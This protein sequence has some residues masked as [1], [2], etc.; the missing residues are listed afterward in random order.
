MLAN[1]N[2]TLL[3][4]L[5]PAKRQ[6]DVRDTKLK[7]F[8]IR[9][10]PSGKMHYVCSFKR[11]RRI[12]LGSTDVLT[13]MQARDRAKEILGD[14]TK[15]IDPHKI[16]NE[17]SVLSLK[18]F[19]ENEY[20]AWVTAHRKSG[21]E[22]IARIKRCFFKSFGNKPLHE[23]VIHD[24]EKWRTQ[25][26]NQ[27]GKAISVNRDLIALR[28]AIAQAVNWGLIEKHPLE[29]LKPLKVDNSPKVRYLNNE[30]EQHLREAL[31]KREDKLRAA[32][33]RYNQWRKERGYDS[34]PSLAEC[35]FA[36]YVK[37]MVILSLNTGLR[38]GELFNLT[39]ENIDLKRANLTVAGESAK[40]GKT[41]HIPLNAEALDALQSWSKQVMNNDEKLVFANK[42]GQRF[43]HVKRSWAGVLREAEIQ[44]FRWHDMRHHFAS[45]LVMAGVD[46]NTVRELLGHADTKMT[47]RYAHLAPEHKAEAVAKLVKLKSSEIMAP[48]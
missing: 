11:G 22:T 6:Y 45:R 24:L 25:K 17:V 18:D 21:H 26:L 32:R 40:S 38:R 7:G 39:W 30:E 12:N 33:E 16:K 3:T 8:L 41:R 27:G 20:K 13:P 10:N 43:N 4:Q 15:G 2:N 34:F 5:K 28:A 1:I 36:D 44:N 48:A 14:A 29:K 23:L 35:V 9:V 31:D 19:I 46:L 37:P 47:L 42:D